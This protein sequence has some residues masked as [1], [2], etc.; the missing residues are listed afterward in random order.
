MIYDV[1]IIGGGVTGAAIAHELSKY[2]LKVA[3]LEKEADVAMGASKANS[4]IVHAGFD[5][6][7]GSLKAKLNVRGNELMED[8]CQQLEV[9][10]KRTG[11]LVVGRR[12]S[13]IEELEKLAAR[14]A[15]NGVEGLKV[16]Q[17]DEMFALE[18]GLNRDAVAALYAPSAGIVC[19]YTL[20]IALAEN[21]AQ[22]GVEV[23][24]GTAV[25]GIEKDGNKVT[26]VQ[27]SKGVFKANWILNCAGVWA[28]QVAAMVEPPSFSIQGF[29]GEY[30]LLDKKAGKLVRHVIF[31]LPNEKTK[32]IL[33]TPTVSGNVLVG[34]N[35]VA[36]QDKEDNSVNE[37][38]IQEVLQGAKAMVNGIKE[39]DII[40]TFAGI[41]AVS[42]SGEFVIGPTSVKGFI[43][44][45][46][47]QSPGL[48]AAPAIAEFVAEILEQEGLELKAKAN[49]VA[50]REHV[51]K[52]NYASNEERQEMVKKDRRYG[53][54]ICRCET[55][56]AGEIIDALKGPVG[57]KTIDAVKR[58]TRAGMG[59]CQGG[60]CSF[61]V[62][63]I[64]ARE[65]GIPVNE[66]SKDGPGSEMVQ[67]KA[68]G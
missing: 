13:D 18:P 35:R 43:N 56:T 28:D 44:V 33:V 58:R 36:V 21:A 46:G 67:E 34:P 38:G 27:T 39:K 8:L 60:F 26:G 65:L 1:V 53:E 25:T 7:P 32:G 9:P 19:P 68:I 49:F 57:A 10:F 29:R 17:G 23:F 50:Q 48:T 42:D 51:F 2:E 31:P 24:T 12:Q 41:R 52:F 62:I 15:E 54:I 66:I 11:S 40:A 61:R 14:G 16:V 5:P 22:N 55:V 37:A 20:T 6:K 63:N 59:R 3:L 4:G 64:M 30:C 45:G 47:I